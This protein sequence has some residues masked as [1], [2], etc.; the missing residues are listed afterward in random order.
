MNIHKSSFRCIASLACGLAITLSA[1][2]CNANPEA[3]PEA[4]RF[5]SHSDA[6]L[7]VKAFWEPI[8]SS[9]SGFG[10]WWSELRDFRPAEELH[11]YSTQDFAALLPNRDVRVGDTW[12]IDKESCVKFL[13]QFH[14]GATSVEHF[15]NGDSPEDGLATLARYNDQL[16]VIL[17]RFHGVFVLK[18]GWLTPGQFQ[19]T[20][21][22]ERKTGAAKFFRCKVPLAAVNFDANHRILDGEVNGQRIDPK[23]PP[24]ATDSGVI[25]R[26]ELLG[27]EESL[28]KSPEWT[29]SISDDAAWNRIEKEFYPFRQIEW[30]AFEQALAAARETGKP[31]H[32]VSVDG[33]LCDESCCGS[34]KALR[35]GPLS[36]LRIARL[37][38]AKCI[39]TWVLNK[40]LKSLRDNA[41]DAD[42]QALATAVL[43]GRQPHSPVDSM[44]F[45]P[46]LRLISVQA[47][48]DILGQPRAA[49]LKTYEGFLTEAFEKLRKEND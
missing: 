9:G 44:V 30:V 45:S 48:N 46:K 29:K 37:V 26:M 21:V 27:G 34:G 42:S 14:D 25:P 35:A 19:Y 4:V 41:D 6:T 22:V 31:L 8:T 3:K 18:E 15:N 38:N 7:D 24:I 23:N 20:L 32:V 39:N 12:R 43:A 47:A 36:D 1:A 16:A 33:T 2:P 10:Q 11:R 28:V 40:R 17:A 49:I 5:V 13:K